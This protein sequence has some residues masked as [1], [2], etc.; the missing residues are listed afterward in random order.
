[1]RVSKFS[2][3]NLFGMKEFESDG[4]SIELVGDN[5]T[6]KTSI[7][8]AFRYCLQNKSNRDY[9]IR[10]GEEEG[11]VIL[12]TDAGIRVHRKPRTNKADYKS[13]KEAGVKG[14]KTESFLRTIFTELQLN[15][16]EF[17][18]YTKDEQNRII[19]DLIEF[20]WDMNWIKEQFG[21]IVPDVNYEQN[22]LC[23][24]HDIQADEG[25]YFTKR[26]DIN[27]DARHKAAFV[28]EI[29][30]KLPSRYNAAEWERAN[31]G[32]F[33]KKVERIQKENA[34]IEKAKAIV[35]NRDNKSR[36]FQADYEIKVNA[37]NKETA[38]DRTR[39][40]NEIK[41]LEDQIEGY[42]RHLEGIEKG[43]IANI[44]L[45]KA[46]YEKNIA[47]FD[48]EVK[49][50]IETAKKEITPYVELQ[51]EATHMEKMKSFVNEY[52][53]MK[54]Y[55]KQ[56][57]ELTTESAEIT[58]K[59]EHAR[60]LPGEILAT[61]N[62]PIKGLTVVD[63]MPLINGLPISNL[64]DG[65]KLNL[66]IDIATQNEET[67]DILLIDGVEKLSKVNRLK[68]Y[69]KLKEMGCQFIATRTNDAPELT[70]IEI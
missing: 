55:E 45:A 17:L 63:G 20:D 32:E 67:L 23:V 57:E 21:E 5:A 19:L 35:E 6:G 48:G 7:I 62:I 70:V 27:R 18:S 43:R 1:M 53:S 54:E 22:I 12:E 10:K 33:Y 60:T 13:I 58:E 34:A 49:D 46:E 25:Y 30:S 61:S 39:T 66:C 16:T 41:R 40:E 2:I 69:L 26:Q 3:K 36:G 11:E 8:D 42:K 50:H 24:L 28:E 29:G 65:E 9:I 4:K 47:Q 14:E 44:K 52:K 37:I 56:V 31:L 68:M 15:P 64:S 38:S 59:I 51:K